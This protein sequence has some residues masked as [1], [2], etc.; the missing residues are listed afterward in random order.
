MSQRHAMMAQVPGKQ[1]AVR[2]LKMS[3]DLSLV[4]HMSR[5]PRLSAAEF[6]LKVREAITAFRDKYN[7]RDFNTYFSEYYDKKSRRCKCLPVSIF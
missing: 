3:K 7:E 1:N 5:D 4:M 2:R 6:D